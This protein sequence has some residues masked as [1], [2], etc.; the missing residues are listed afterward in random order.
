[1]NVRVSM[2][3]YVYRDN[4]RKVRQRIL[5][6]RRAMGIVV[7]EQVRNWPCGMWGDR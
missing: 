1:M 4:S 6:F 5:V 3:G 2:R 7:N